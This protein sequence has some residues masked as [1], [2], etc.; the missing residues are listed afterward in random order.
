M[1]KIINLIVRP[2][3]NSLRVDIFINKRENSLSRTRIKN[4]ILKEKLKLNNKIIIS[5]SKKISSGDKIDLEIPKPKEA[6]L[7]PYDFKLD[8]IYKDK[9]LLVINKPAGI[10]MHPGAG[11]YNN[12]IVNALMNYCGNNLSTIG[13][14]YRPGIIHRI[15]KDTSG[16]VVIAKN[17]LTHE[18]LSIQFN[19]HTITRVY[20][21]LVW[22]KLRPQSG[23]INTLITRSSKNRQLMEVGISKGKKAITNYKTL[24]AFENDKTPTLSLIECKL[25]TGRTHQIRVHM[26][27]KGNNILGDKKYK[28]KFKKLK[29]IDKKLENLIC[30]LDRQFLH[31][32]T[33]GFK[34]PTTEEELEFTSI[35]PQELENIL[36]MLRNTNK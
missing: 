6:S 20:Q 7:K 30:K 22:G 35:L 23:R 13:D 18:N 4:L 32:K 3:E 24:E 33:L 25:E 12:T 19:K 27:H 14:E 5:P 1:K 10:I 28:K 2:E 29:N 34:H 36:K 21:L 16:L 26:S 8:I 31:A 9:D 17:N 11:N 15:D